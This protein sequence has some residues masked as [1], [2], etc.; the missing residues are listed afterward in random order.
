[1]KNIKL[2]AAL[3]ATG[4]ALG[5]ATATAAAQ[6]TK[7]EG[8]KVAVLV[9]PV[10]FALDDTLADGCWVR[11]YDEKN[12]QGD[13]NLILGPL[14]MPVTAV[15][16][17][18]GLEEPGRNFESAVLGPKADMIIYDDENYQ[19]RQE[20]LSEQTVPKLN[21]EV[22]YFDAVRSFK[23]NCDADDVAASD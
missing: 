19:G 12:Y 22:G 20:L 18:P 6:D 11:L 9:T 7:Q 14:N 2:P 5:L 8:P 1:M 23:L 3:A 13:L 4:L 10:A 15:G 17:M 21:A 16:I